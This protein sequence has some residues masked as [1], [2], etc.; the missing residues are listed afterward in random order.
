MEKI[1]KTVD[2]KSYSMEEAINIFINY[3]LRHNGKIKDRFKNIRVEPYRYQLPNGCGALANSDAQSNTIRIIQGGC[4]IITFFHELKHLA[5]S[6]QSSNGIWLSNWGSIIED[7]MCAEISDTEKGKVNIRKGTIGLTMR[8]ATAELFASKVYWDLCKSS[9][10]K[11]TKETQKRTFYDEEI[12][13]FKMICIILGIDE[14][15][16]LSWESDNEICRRR[17]IYCFSKLTNQE[18]FWKKLEAYMDYIA[19]VKYIKLTEP[20]WVLSN[21]TLNTVDI[22]KKNIND[23]FQFCMQEDIQRIYFLSNGYS[24]TNF[25]KVYEKKLEELRK[26]ENYLHHSSIGQL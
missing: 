4:D 16:I 24:Y 9:I 11:A 26:L 10:E 13:L 3:T 20:N 21:E 8:E 23:C 1:F 18:N 6:W 7:N 19:M 17:L 14:D 12:I 5:D 25:E 15:E 22:C 2:G